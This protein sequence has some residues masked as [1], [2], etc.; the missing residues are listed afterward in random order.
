MTEPSGY[1]T[2]TIQPNPEHVRILEV[3]LRISLLCQCVNEVGK[4]GRTRMNTGV[5]AAIYAQRLWHIPTVLL[6]RL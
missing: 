2:A 1:I 5:L 3:S 6:S 4:L